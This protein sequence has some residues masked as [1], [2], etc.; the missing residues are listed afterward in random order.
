MKLKHILNPTSPLS[1]SMQGMFREKGAGSYAIVRLFHKTD[2]PPLCAVYCWPLVKT[3]GEA[4]IC[5]I[6][7]L[8]EVLEECEEYLR[9]R[10]L[11]DFLEHIEV[12]EHAD[13]FDEF[14]HVRYE[15][16]KHLL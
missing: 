10:T 5:T 1:P 7:E 8:W 2:F 9:T 12:G 13:T 14:E 6:D 3:Q 11:E 16:V 4:Y 15:H